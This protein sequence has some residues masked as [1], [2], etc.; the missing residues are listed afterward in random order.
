[1]IHPAL[2][3]ANFNNRYAQ[4][5]MQGDPRSQVKQYDRAG[6]SRGGGAYNQ[7]GIQGAQDFVRG[8]AEAYAGQQSDRLYNQSMAMQQQQG[9]DQY[10][11]S[12]AAMQQQ[13]QYQDTMAR[14]QRANMGTQFATSLLG[15]LLQ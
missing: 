9:D 1:M 7:A 5:A 2:S 13:Q 12:A 8:V 15:G 6:V 3:R 14:L 11:Q 10:R 4:A